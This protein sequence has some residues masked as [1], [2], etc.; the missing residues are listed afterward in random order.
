MRASGNSWAPLAGFALASSGNQMAWL[1]F[2]PVTTGAAAH[3]HVPISSV[4]LL[5]EIFPLAYIVLAMPAGRALDRSFKGWLGAGAGLSALGTLVRLGG[6]S[7]A[8]F[9]WVLAGQ[10]LVAA[11][12]PLMLNSITMLARRY[13][14]EQDRPTGI[15]ICSGGTF[16][17]FVLAFLTAAL[18]GPGRAGLVL[19]VGA[20][21]AVAGSAVLAVALWRSPVPFP[22]EVGAAPDGAQVRRLL[23]DPVMKGLVAFVF[24]G[25]GVFVSLTT[26]AQPLL[27]P[28]GVTAAVADTILIS[29]V[30]AGSVS[31]AVFPPLVARR[32]WQLPA[33][34]VGGL[35]T[36]VAC[37]VLALVPGVVDAGVS[38][39]FVGL[40]LLPGLPVMLEVAERR[41]GHEAAAGAG[42]LWLAGNTGGIVVA[43]VAGLLQ[44]QPDWAFTVLAA[45]V[46]LVVPVASRLRGM[47]APVDVP[48]VEVVRV[49][50]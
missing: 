21:Y 46:L 17:G 13:L 6:M 23:A 16:A 39:S 2:A 45:V 32:G 34:V 42:L 36:V 4:G 9:G 19:V 43:V 12:Q 1:V 30:L 22:G 28:A 31:S 5:S 49:E 8:G 20:A 37:T 40:L 41:C 3:F 33:L 29:M 24:V 35:T 18:L 26:W 48:A 47:L 38:L 25:F 15:A 50:E 11:S 7:S 44:S 27:Q 10:A 14:R